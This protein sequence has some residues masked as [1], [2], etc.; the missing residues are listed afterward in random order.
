M[1]G[2]VPGW[3]EV[4]RQLERSTAVAYNNFVLINGL[5][6][7]RTLGKQGMRLR[8]P[9]STVGDFR[10]VPWRSLGCALRSKEDAGADRGKILLA[11]L[12]TAGTKL[13][14]GREYRVS[15]K[16]KPASRTSGT[17]GNHSRGETF[18]KSWDGHIGSFSRVGG[19]QEEYHRCGGLSHQVG[20]DEGRSICD[21]P[22]RG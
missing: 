17:H 22:G 13:R 5:L 11:T 10:H 2:A 21:G 18:R 1:Q 3:V 4:R 15:D 9:G 19:G 12:T 14:A 6:H 16:E 20:R 8:P 7:R